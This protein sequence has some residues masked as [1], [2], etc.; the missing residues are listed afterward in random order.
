MQFLESTIQKSGCDCFRPA[1]ADVEVEC[2]PRAVNQCRG[3]VIGMSLFKFGPIEIYLAQLTLIGA[4]F[5][6]TGFVT[7]TNK[8][9]FET[10]KCSVNR[11][12]L[13]VLATSR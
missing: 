2:W 5:I 4:A 12:D 3:D 6:L 13:I 11:K 9:S 8:S 1:L 10:V 7:D